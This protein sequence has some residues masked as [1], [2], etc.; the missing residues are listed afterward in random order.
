MLFARVLSRMLIVVAAVSIEY[1]PRQ[2]QDIVRFRRSTRR[3]VMREDSPL[4]ECSLHQDGQVG[5]SLDACRC[6]RPCDQCQVR[7]SIKLL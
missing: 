6:L 3:V 7:Q 5:G 4:S 2:A 1:P